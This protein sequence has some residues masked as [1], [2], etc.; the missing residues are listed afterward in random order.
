MTYSFHI[1]KDNSQLYSYAF[2]PVI[3]DEN[4]KLKEKNEQIKLD[5]N[6]NVIEILNDIALLMRHN[7]IGNFF[8]CSIVCLEKSTASHIESFEI[9][10]NLLR[11]FHKYFRLSAD[12]KYSAVWHELH[13]QKKRKRDSVQ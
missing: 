12:K 8:F 3:F 13:F 9:R 1:F 2:C 5:N 6:T 4:E 10:N 11:K 7:G